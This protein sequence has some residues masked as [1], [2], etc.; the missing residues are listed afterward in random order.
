MK[1]RRIMGSLVLALS[2]VAGVVGTGATKAEAKTPTYT[3]LK[4]EKITVSVWGSA[5]KSVSSSSGA[6]KAKKSGSYKAT[7]TAKKG[8]SAKVVIRGKNGKSLS[9]K[10]KVKVPKFNYTVK[11]VYVSG[12]QVKVTYEVINKSGVYID[13]IKPMYHINDMSG[14]ELKSD[15]AYF[16]RLLP[17]KKAYYTVSFYNSTGAS[18]GVPTLSG[19]KCSRGYNA[20]K[21][22]YSNVASKVAITEKS[23]GLTVKNKTSKSVDASI[24][25]L[26]YDASGQ[27]IEVSQRSAYL[28][29]KGSTTISTYPPTGAARSEMVVRAVTSKYLG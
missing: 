5:I 8:G 17:G 18:I 22:K 16:Y 19:F 27:L 14:S 12:N 6:V 15:S 23:G 9:Y 28:T 11:S 1:F 24:D 7:I 25:I 29:S 13:S 26:Y 2:L 21:Y 4:G 3:L 10:I 20:F